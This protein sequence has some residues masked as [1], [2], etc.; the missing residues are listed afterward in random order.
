MN[1]TLYTLN[2]GRYE[3]GR[4]VENDLLQSELAPRHSGVRLP[5]EVAGE[6]S[7]QE[8]ATLANPVHIGTGTRRR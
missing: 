6:V 5:P 3:V 4:I 8:L 2:S 1:D 7:A